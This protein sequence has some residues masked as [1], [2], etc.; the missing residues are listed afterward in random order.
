M[1]TKR[2]CQAMSAPLILA[3]GNLTVPFGRKDGLTQNHLAYTQGDDTPY[4][5]LE[6]E[7]LKEKSVHL[8]PLD[9]NRT[10]ASFEGQT[11]EFMELK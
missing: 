2:A 10:K 4:E 6:I 8:R 11:I 7:A 1:I 9:S 5:I 3:S